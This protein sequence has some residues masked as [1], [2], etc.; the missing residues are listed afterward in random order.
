LR[1][2]AANEP[3]VRVSADYWGATAD[4]VLDIALPGGVVSRAVPGIHFGHNAVDVDLPM[5]DQPLDAKAVLRVA[6]MRTEATVQLG[7]AADRVL[8]VCPSTHTDIGYTHPQPEV[9]RRH[10]AGLAAVLQAMSDTDDYPEGARLKWNSEVTWEIEQLEALEPGSVE[11]FYRRCREGRMG[12][13]A[14]YANTLTGLCGHEQICR[15]AYPAARIRHD[16][17]VAVRTATSTDNPTYVWSVAS[18]L[19]RSGVDNFAVGCNDARWVDDWNHP[20]HPPMPWQGPDGQTV[21]HW[22]GPGY[23]TA[24]NLGLLDNLETAE[25]RVPGFVAAQAVPLQLAYGGLG[26]N[27]LVTREQARRLSDV[28]RAWNATYASPRLVLAT[29]DEYFAEYRRSGRQAA[30]VSGDEGTYWEDGAASSA[31]EMALNRE[32]QELLGT[33]ETLHSLCSLADPRHSYPAAALHRVVR[34]TLLF[35]EHTWGSFNSISDPDTDFQR[36]QWTIKAAYATDGNREARECTRIGLAALAAQV[37]AAPGR[38]LLVYNPLAWERSEV[39]VCDPPAGPP[40]RVVDTVTGQAVASQIGPDGRLQFAA[41]H[42]PPLGYRV[43]R[44]EPAT[45]TAAAV[46]G[47]AHEPGTDVR[48]D[49]G[50][51][52]LVLSPAAGGGI[53]SLRDRGG[54]EWLDTSRFRLAQCLR[55]RCSR[56]PW[57]ERLEERTLST[58]GDV[59]VVAGDLTGQ[60]SMSVNLP[61]L[62][63]A[64]LRLTWSRLSPALGVELHCANKP[65]SLDAEAVYLAFPFVVAN[66]RYHYELPLAV[67]EA[68]RDQLPRACRNWYAI[69]HFVDASNADRGVTIAF[70]DAFLA[71]FGDIHTRE[72]LLR[73]PPGNGSVFA[74]VMGNGWGTNYKRDQEGEELFRFL[75]WPHEGGFDRAKAIRFGFEQANPL[76]VTD[77][78]AGGSGP[79]PP[80]SAALL[81]VDGP[82]TGVLTLKQAEFGPGTVVRLYDVAGQGG[83][84]VL[85]F[86]QTLKGATLC[87]LVEEDQSALSV[88]GPEVTVPIDRNGVATVRVQF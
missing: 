62:G 82:A 75:I 30:A 43:F 85:R 24:K 1:S 34:N 35:D 11:E 29:F 38:R 57:N 53:T 9:A 21:L 7:P 68:E 4:G 70:R 41:E 52:R 49:T 72:Q 61:G 76:L 48:L 31:R 5:P 42:V 36:G 71:E 73:V 27:S 87:N 69:N 22:F 64:V 23:A 83:A 55:D 80:T 10:A 17:G 46:A 33:A 81:T 39:V 8:Y 3:R 13:S 6:G 66:A 15:L 50:T 59:K 74:Y 14:N 79:L 56:E 12:L 18:V 88:S 47:S 40:C 28:V 67:A 77:L 44:W 19:A 86:R 37:E 25:E 32:T 51:F 2:R 63:P 16:R 26:D 45:D 84:R 65:K 58:G 60:A 20:L 78:A 54:R